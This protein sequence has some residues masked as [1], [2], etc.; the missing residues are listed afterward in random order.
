M[1]VAAWW[2]IGAPV[3]MPVAPI[4][5]GE[6][7]PCVSYAPFRDDQT[8]LDLSTRIEPWQIEDDLKRLAPLTGCVR[9][10][11]V[12]LGLD[13]IAPIAQRYGLKVLQGL[14]L[15]RMP[16]FNRDQIATAIALAQRYPD[17]ILALVVGNEVLLRGE[18]SA[19]GLASIIREIK[20]QVP[21]P[22][23]YADVWEFWLRHPDVAQAVDFVT[24]HV[25]PYWEDFPIPALEAAAHVAAIHQRVAARF[26]GKEIVVGE[27]G[28]P[29]AGRMREGALPSPSNQARTVQEVL[30]LANREGFRLS[31]IE[32]FDQP[33]KRR[34]E[35]TVG[36]H[37]GL[38]TA[39]TRAPKFEWGR[40][41]SDHPHW[42]W[43]ALAGL[44]LAGA[45]FA[46]A[47]F[48][49]RGVAQ[50]ARLAAAPAQRV[51]LVGVLVDA[52]IPGVLIGWAIE[53]IPS[54]SFGLGG[55]VRSLALAVVAIAAP[56]AAT[57]A[58]VRK[59]A[60]VPFRRVLGRRSERPPDALALALGAALALVT[61]LAIQVA[62]GLVF[63]PRYRDFPFA[64]LT[65]AVVPFAVLA[66]AGVREVGPRQPAETIAAAV[67]ALSA[68]Y[69][70]LNEG[71][72]NWQALWLAGALVVLAATLALPR[73]AR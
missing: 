16:D 53:K 49:G 25:L 51:I 65:A 22:V 73:A 72:A 23:T 2:F 7:L 28:W 39:D 38:L 58:L 20:A 68:G 47:L 67:L 44:A 8:P 71:L 17:V 37:W 64:P 62:L 5:A 4:A 12:H 36:G 48:T 63:D 15:G 56:V 18:L 42:L 1:I 10:Y 55:W 69:I 46:A 31:L 61:V 35:G 41:V 27:F 66:A 54:E 30:A 52:V 13:Q 50:P 57:A 26:P 40:P 9:T 6:K 19:D 45:V 14:W 70:A 60:P 21:V 24:I 34:L 29:S 33:W 3:T 43:L 32:A 59:S 11:S